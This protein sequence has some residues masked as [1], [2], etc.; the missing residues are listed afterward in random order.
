MSIIRTLLYGWKALHFIMPI[1]KGGNTTTTTTTTNNNNK[2]NN[3]NNTNPVAYTALVRTTL[4][5]AAVCWAP[6]TEGHLS[7]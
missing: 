4:E 2:S 7:A 6:Y 3:N 5:Y 1:H